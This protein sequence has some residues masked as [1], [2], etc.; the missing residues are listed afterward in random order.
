MRISSGVTDQYVYFVAV[1]ATDFTSRETG[2]S[3][4]TVYRSRNGGAAAAMTTP[5][6]NETD[7]TNMPGVYELLLDEDMAIDSGDDS[8]EMAFHITH[9]GMAPVT[10]TIELYRSKITAGNTLDVTATG[11]AGIDWGNVEN[12]STAVDLSA[13]DIQLADTI[14]TYTGNTLQT[15]DV[16]TV[17]NDLANGTDGLGAI[18]TAVDAIPTS[19]PTAAA[20][21]DAVWDEPV[22][23][24]VSAGTFGKTDADIL[25]DTG[26]L[27][28]NQ[29][30]WLTVTGHATEAKQDAIDANVDAI[31]IDTSTT[32]DN[33]LTDIKG[34][35]FVKDT[36]SLVDI[37]AYVDLIDDGTSGL[38]KIAT[39]AAAILDDTGTN[40]VALLAA[41]QASIDAIETDTGTTLPALLPDALVGGAIKA[42]LL[43]ISGSTTAADTLEASMLATISGTLTSFTNS[44]TVVDTGLTAIAPTDDMLTGRVIVFY[45]DTGKYEAA[46]ITAYTAS[47]GTLTVTTLA[48]TVTGTASY[49]IV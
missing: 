39:D 29:G 4:W 48:S 33:H 27:Q 44:T 10:R 28:T 42:D 35:G 3:T 22:A 38:A 1:D 23:G 26:E 34:T 7:A 20:I 13:T 16:T 17:I 14:T 47:S 5:T 6:I 41:T 40:G 15:G 31:L 19:N 46:R 32:L 21:A 30:N 24:H 2:L 43:S 8:Q 11:A 36:H 9:A 45:T 18:K 37:E 49:V 12:Q 25:A